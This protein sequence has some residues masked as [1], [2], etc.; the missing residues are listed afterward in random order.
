M[1]KVLKDLYWWKEMVGLLTAKQAMPVGLIVS[2]EPVRTGHDNV[3]KAAEA[4]G[5][6]TLSLGDVDWSFWGVGGETE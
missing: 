1:N 6:V 4:W 2:G 5:P 3:G